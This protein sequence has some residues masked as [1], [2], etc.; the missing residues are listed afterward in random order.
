MYLRTCFLSWIRVRF[1]TRIRFRVM[2]GPWL[3]C[4]D[5]PAVQRLF[6]REKGRVRIVVGY[7]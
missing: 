4:D 2:V 1:R 5:Y 6:Q 3:V 7:C